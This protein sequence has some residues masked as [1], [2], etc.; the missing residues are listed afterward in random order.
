[1]SKID[2]VDSAF[3][4]VLTSS[5]RLPF[6]GGCLMGVLEEVVMMWYS[7]RNMVAEYGLSM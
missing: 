3:H 7:R 4:M 2:Q 1:M 5:P 6:G